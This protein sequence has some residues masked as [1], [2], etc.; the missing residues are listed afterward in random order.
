MMIRTYEVTVAGSLGRSAR[1]AFSDVAACV[2]GIHV[3][4]PY[5]SEV[6]GYRGAHPREAVRDP[7]WNEFQ[8][9]QDAARGR[10]ALITLAPERPGSLDFIRK[11]A[12]SGVVVALGH[13]AADGPTLRAAAADG[14]RL[15]THLGNGIVS[16]L[17]RHPNP[18]WEQ[19]A[20]DA[21]T[22]RAAE[23][24]GLGKRLGTI[25]KGKL[26]HLVVMT[27][28]L[29][30]ENAKVRYVLIDGLKFE[31][32]PEDPARAKAKGKGAASRGRRGDAAEKPGEEDQ[33]DGTAP[34]SKPE[35]A[36]KPQAPAKSEARSIGSRPGTS[37]ATAE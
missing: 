18:I 12:L 24:A 31:I 35:T 36:A 33:P 26:G 30:D 29:G 9:L 23:I 25:E 17:P 28:P 5:I 32:K 20:L 14:A 22:R 13:T 21:L 16:T 19:A 4:G 7:D 11:A 1:E 27:G 6:D 8:A 2:A 37:M 15:S 10:I 3:E 34:E